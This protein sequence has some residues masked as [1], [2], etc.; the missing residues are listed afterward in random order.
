MAS[1]F[2]D[3]LQRIAELSGRVQK[4]QGRLSAD[5]DTIAALEE[6][7][8]DH[9]SRLQD[10]KAARTRHAGKLSTL[11]KEVKRIAADLDAASDISDDAGPDTTMSDSR[12]EMLH[13][14]SHRDSTKVTASNSVSFTTSTP[15]R[16]PSTHYTSV[17]E[18]YPTVIKFQGKWQEISCLE[19]DCNSSY[20]GNFLKGVDGIRNHFSQQ[21]KALGRGKLD[22]LGCCAFRSVSDFDV[23]LLR[24]GLPAYERPVEPRTQRDTTGH[25]GKRPPPATARQLIQ[26]MVYPA[27]PTVV[28]V[29]GTTVELTCKVCGTNAQCEDSSKFMKGVRGFKVH[30]G[31]LHSS[32]VGQMRIEEFCDLRP[33]SDHDQD[34]LELCMPP[35]DHPIV[36]VEPRDEEESAVLQPQT[37]ASIGVGRAEEGPEASTNN[38]FAAP[39]ARMSAAAVVEDNVN[40][41]GLFSDSEG[42]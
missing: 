27:Y 10:A 33:I 2:S 4:Y 5:D 31:A 36:A 12:D 37:S 41:K 25:I 39:V 14:T 16:S 34:L 17:H 1:S 9:E 13:D 22:I 35:T 15:K 26:E 21:H 24:K 23:E 32:G 29:G 42:G 28:V 3:K 38:T 6:G 11:K 20:L 40:M 18:H 8:K 7:I 19:C 30:Y